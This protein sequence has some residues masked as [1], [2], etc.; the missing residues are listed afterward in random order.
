[1]NHNVNI[2]YAGYLIC[3]PCERVVQPSEGCGPQVEELPIY[4]VYLLFCCRILLAALV[5]SAFFRTLKCRQSIYLC[6]LVVTVGSIFS[7]VILTF[8][9]GHNVVV[10]LVSWLFFKTIR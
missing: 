6:L 7:G 3:G 4:G 9:Y 1:M 2:G 5:L 10:V 8:T